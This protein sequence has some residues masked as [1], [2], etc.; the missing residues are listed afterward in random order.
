MLFLFHHRGGNFPLFLFCDPYKLPS[1]QF[2]SFRPHYYLNCFVFPALGLL[3]CMIQIFQTSCCFFSNQAPLWC[4]IDEYQLSCL[5]D[6]HDLGHLH[7]ARKITLAGVEQSQESG[8]ERCVF[9]P[10][11]PLDTNL[12]KQFSTECL[13]TKTKVITLT[14]QNNTVNQSKLKVNTCIYYIVFREMWAFWLV[15]SWSRFCHTDRFHGNGHKLCILCFQQSWQ[16]QNKHG[17]SAI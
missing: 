5:N 3:V 15:L 16:I 11:L 7:S 6:W 12:Y 17:P 2:I 4:C 1:T 14:S 10:N 8:T 9:I 13:K